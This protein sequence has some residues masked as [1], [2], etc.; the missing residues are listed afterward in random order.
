MLGKELAGPLAKVCESLGVEGSTS[1]KEIPTMREDLRH[2]AIEFCL[3]K[4]RNRLARP[5]KVFQNLDKMSD[6]WVQA[7][8]GP[9][10]GLPAKMFVEAMA[11][12]LYLHSPAVVDSGLV[13]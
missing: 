1:R 13:G 7:L 6:P 5:V 10:T 2:Q 11:T 12:R 9:R 3:K 8:P 4:H